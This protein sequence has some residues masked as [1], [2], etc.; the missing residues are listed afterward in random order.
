MKYK[1]FA[2]VTFIGMLVCLLG[3]AGLT[4]YVDPFFHYHAGTKGIE[5]PL[6]SER[7]QNDG[8]ARS[9]EYDAIVTG[10]SMTE[11]F[12]TDQFDEY[13]GT[14]SIKI[15]L[16]GA[17]YYELANQLDRAFNYNDNIR[18]V[19]RALDLSNMVSVWDYQ[20]YEDYPDYLYDNNIFNDVQY[21]LN[22]EIF[23]DYTYYVKE[24]MD[25][26]GKTTPMYAYKVWYTSKTAKEMVEA[27][28]RKEKAESDTGLSEEE[29][30]Q[31][32]ENLSYNVIRT[33][34][35]HPETEF[36]FYF[37]PYSILW[38]YDQVC[39]GRYQAVYETQAIAIDALLKYDNVKLYSF[40]DDY[41]FIGS[42]GNYIDTVHYNYDCSKKIVDK[43]AEGTGRITLE[44]KDQYLQSLGF[45][46]VFDY[47]TY[48]NQILEN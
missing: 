33:V 29:L 31:L 1:T 36:I 9:F 25:L 7:Y 21:L 13:F 43:I 35:A 15:P 19:F 47:D 4:Y 34:E 22:K 30:Q 24:Y 23:Y 27:Y 10:T 12:N 45:Y 41:I 2:I 17:S 5:Y 8:I 14:K 11:N 40:F 32:C 42:L 44:N 28:E 3:F 48:L 16:S 37:P 38:W 39:N 26:G 20:S 46:S 18:V 6:W